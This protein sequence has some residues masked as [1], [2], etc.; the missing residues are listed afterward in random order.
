MK[1]RLG[2]SLIFLLKVVLTAVL[3]YFVFRKV[4]LKQ[5]LI[6]ILSLP[7]GIL[8]LV[9]LLSAIRHYLQYNNWFWALKL[10]PEYIITPGQVFR[11]YMMG[12]PLR[13]ILP[14]GNGSFAKVFFVNNSS[15][16][17]TAISTLAEKAVM[18]WSLVLF[19]IMASVPFY[20]EFPVWMKISAFALVAS[21]PAFALFLMKRVKVWQRF[22]P[23]SR[24]YGP[25]MLLIQIFAVLITMLQY[26]LLLNCMQ[27]I[28][29]KQVIIRMSLTQFSNIIPITISGLGLRESF[30]MHFLSGSGITAAQAV[31]ATL[32]LFLMQD[33]IPSVIG[34]LY[35]VKFK[36]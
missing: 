13:F 29:F 26:W 9:L 25:N 19:A 2:K 28:A 24:K 21:L 12:V 6:S 36:I 20:P 32:A 1:S 33:I 3:L 4:D 15:K 35:F 5:V 18:T 23:S 16:M 14:G 27:T 10:N 11:T 30:A 22:E 34:S 7:A 17:A 8:L 31:T